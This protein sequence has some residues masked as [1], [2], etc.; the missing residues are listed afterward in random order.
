MPLIPLGHKEE[1]ESTPVVRSARVSYRAH[2]AAL[3]GAAPRP[4]VRS[5]RALFSAQVRA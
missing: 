2:G 5:Y 3:A 1:T 4:A